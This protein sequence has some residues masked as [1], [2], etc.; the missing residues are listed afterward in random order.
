MSKKNIKKV[1]FLTNTIK[2]YRVPILN[3][4]A[5]KYDLTV[6]Y[7]QQ[8]EKE[9]IKECNFKTIFSPTKKVWK[10]VIHKDNIH[11]LTKGFDV[12]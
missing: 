6:L 1:L 8:T 10:F 4:I 3:I 9:V 11:D 5:N 12:F 7:S 2:H